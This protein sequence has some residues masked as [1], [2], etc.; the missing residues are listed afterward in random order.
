MSEEMKQSS[1]RTW[2]FMYSLTSMRR[3]WIRNLGIVFFLAL[4]V[5]L[6][7]TVFAWSSTSTYIV[8]EDHFTAN[9]YQ[10][11]AS[12]QS[13]VNTLQNLETE[14]DVYDFIEAIDYYPTT[15]G[16]L[17]NS[18]LPV[19]DWYSRFSP[20]PS[21]GYND[22]RTLA[23]TNEMIEHIEG[24]FV[25]EGNSQLERGQ[26]LISER[27][28]YHAYRTYGLRL[29]PG[30]IIG[31]DVLLEQATDRFGN[32]SGATRFN[33]EVVSLSNFTIAGIYKLK[34]LSTLTA[35]AF[36]SFLRID[37]WP[38]H[39]QDMEA[40]LGLEDSVML[41]KEEF[42][43]YSLDT[44]SQEG[45]FPPKALFR[46]S[47]SDLLD[48]GTHDIE[49]NLLTVK[50]LV[51]SRHSRIDII[52]AVSISDISTLI[53]TYERA[54]MFTLV[55]VP[56]MLLS[57]FITIFTAESSLSRRKIEISVLRS[58]G[59]SFNQI[60]ASIMWESCILAISGFLFGLGLATILTP[61]LGSSNGLFNIN[62]EEYLRFFLALRVPPLILVISCVITLYLP[63]L[64]LYQIERRIDV[65]EVGVPL[66]GES[67]EK[68]QES[69]FRQLLAAFLVILAIT[70][71]IPSVISPYGISG[72][73]GIILVALILLIASYLGSR[74]VQLSVS[75]LITRIRN[76]LGERVLYVVQ[77]LRRRRG[78]FVPLMVI[79]TL[80]L[81][82][83]TMMLM[84]STSFQTSLQNDVIFSYGADIRLDCYVPYHVSVA[85]DIEELDGVNAVTPVMSRLISSESDRFFLQGIMP[86]KYLEIGTFGL[87]TF[88]NS[89]PIDALG[90]LHNEVDGVI[91][92]DAYAN[93]LNKTVGDAIRIRLLNILPYELKI[94]ATMTSAPGFGY[95]SHYE[96]TEDTIASN[97]GFQVSQDGF[98]L[99]NYDFLSSV[100]GENDVELFL[101]DADLNNGFKDLCANL[102]AGYRVNLRTPHWNILPETEILLYADDGSFF[103]ST[104][105][106][107]YQE[108]QRFIS[109]FQG[110]TLVGTIVCILMA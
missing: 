79:L 9:S 57:I 96:S 39:E 51:E 43:E 59:A 89:N 29:E 27:L 12:T 44:I 88:P 73:M 22:F 54:Q 31:A 98:M 15:V 92:S 13:D 48:A 84:E 109:G 93:R 62:T 104:Q 14:A 71:L 100:Y 36:P 3:Q 17:T 76:P 25:W 34:S 35:K 8:I 1:N 74:V 86:N 18:N 61:I 108:I 80:S 91:I 55:A 37:P 106:P 4:N 83:A 6:P 94:V 72:I 85:N 33:T 105:D 2:S 10:L 97:L 52:G 75:S 50:V 24:E 47:I 81:T 107:I 40:V 65:H 21:Y 16:I 58:K 69:K 56:V 5:A 64:Y 103:Y 63:G 82:S 45:Y 87:N 32:P 41:L 67:E 70:L 60:T 90:A 77:S 20:M 66:K 19:W 101:V 68:I 102:T 28:V 23:V 53:E 95:S 49:D 38:E 42:D 11:M 26:I 46:A 110:I 7:T 30:M 99:V 78:K